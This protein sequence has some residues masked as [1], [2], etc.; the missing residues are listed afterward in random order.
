MP[1][2]QSVQIWYVCY[3]GIT[4][5]YLPPTQRTIAAFTSQPQGITALWLVLIAPAHEEMARLS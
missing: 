1:C 5:F 2:L 3:K 4:Q